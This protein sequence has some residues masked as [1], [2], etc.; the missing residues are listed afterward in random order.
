MQ[1]NPFQLAERYI[2]IRKKF[3]PETWSDKILLIND[4]ILNPLITIFFLFIKK[5]TL[6]TAIPSIVSTFKLWRDWFEYTDLRMIVQKMYLITMASGGPFIVTNDTTYM[7][8]VWADGVM[9][10]EL[11]HSKKAD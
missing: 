2:Q 8:Y 5:S 1:R 7:P 10:V 11:H 4:L 6:F 9:R 3:S